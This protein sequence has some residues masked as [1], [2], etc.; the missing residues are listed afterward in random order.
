[1]PLGADMRFL[2]VS[3]YPVDAAFAVTRRLAHAPDAVRVQAAGGGIAFYDR[4]RPTSVYVSFPGS[5]YQVELDDASAGRARKLAARVRPA[6]VNDAHTVTTAELRALA[7]S[8]PLYWIGPRA[9]VAYELS[10]TGGDRRY[11]RYLPTGVAA[12]SDRGELTLG[13]Y[14]VADGF[15]ITGAS[16]RMIGAVR[17]PTRDGS[18]AFYLRRR[19]TNVYVAWPGRAVQVE[20][21][22]PSP[23]VARALV[24]SGRVAPVG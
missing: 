22:D 23:G 15:G 11:L 14:P 17:I 7:A 10:Q 18:V 19:P 4:R 21:Y 20:V 3:T 2:T 24:A 16:T 12:G 1:M 13:T 9:G 8:Q 5:S 6:T